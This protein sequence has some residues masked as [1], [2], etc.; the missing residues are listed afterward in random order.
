MLM[1]EG[2][3]EVIGT[4]PSLKLV[5]RHGVKYHAPNDPQ[6]YRHEGWRYEED[7][8]CDGFKMGSSQADGQGI[9]LWPV[10]VAF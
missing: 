1:A 4:P 8:H 10:S 7:G 2:A 5:H 3:W 6:R 9:T